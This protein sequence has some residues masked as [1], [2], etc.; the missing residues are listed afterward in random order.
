MF[1]A[2]ACCRLHVSTAAFDLRIEDDT[3]SVLLLQHLFGHTFKN[4]QCL[5]YIY[6]SSHSLSIAKVAVVQAKIPVYIVQKE[7]PQSFVGLR[8]NVLLT[9]YINISACVNRFQR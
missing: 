2:F 8:K 7:K 6:G 3:R 9:T 5:L 1:A 4:K